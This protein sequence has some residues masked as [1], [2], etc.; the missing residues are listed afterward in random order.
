MKTF[1]VRDLD[2][3]PAAV[4]NAC[5]REGAVRIRRRNGRTYTMRPDMGPERITALPDFRARIERIFPRPF[6]AEQTRR[7]DKLVAGE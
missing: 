2:R 6:T 4:L 1:T 5:D 7:A 3:E